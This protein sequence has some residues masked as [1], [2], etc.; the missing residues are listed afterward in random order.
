ML[1]IFV[2]KLD[3]KKIQNFT[4]ILIKPNNKK[5]WDSPLDLGYIKSVGDNKNSIVSKISRNTK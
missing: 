4:D 5:H 1:Q 2:D 3:Y